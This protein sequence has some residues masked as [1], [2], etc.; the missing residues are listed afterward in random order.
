MFTR[1]KAASGKVT[2]GVQLTYSGSQ[3]TRI[4]MVLPRPISNQYQDITSWEA[5]EC[6]EAACEDGIN[7]YIW[8]DTPEDH[9][10][11]SGQYV[12]SERFDA[13]V[14]HVTTDFSVMKD[15]PEYDAQSEECKKYLGKEANCLIDP[16][17]SKIVSTANSLWSVSG[18]DIVAYAR[19]CLEWTYANMHYGNTNTGL[20]TIDD[21]MQSMTGDCGNYASVFIS[22]LRAKGIPARHVVMVHGSLDEYHVRAEFY[23]PAYGWIPADPTWGKDYFGVFEGKYIVVSQGINTIIRDFDGK[24]FQADLFQT[25]YGWY[26]YR[27]AGNYSFTHKCA[28]LN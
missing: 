14:Y 6:T 4:Y 24:D 1:T 28:G 11:A 18:G 23:V 21:L 3:F 20:H 22:L 13:N 2:N 7:S 10:P 19:K 27:V 25:F 9:I 8:K 15:I 5:P 16:T 12:I 26:W 17:H